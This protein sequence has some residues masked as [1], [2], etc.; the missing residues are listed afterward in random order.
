[1]NGCAFKVSRCAVRALGAGLLL[2][3]SACTVSPN[4]RVAVDAISAQSIPE[5][6]DWRY[7]LKPV[8][9][10]VERTDLHFLE[11]AEHI[12]AALQAQGLRPAKS[13]EFANV[14]IEVDY[15]VSRQQQLVSVPRL[16][17]SRATL[18]ERFCARRD[19]RGR[20]R[21]WRDRPVHDRL[22]LFD[23]ETR[24]DVR[25]T[26]YYRVFVALE[27]IDQRESSQR[28]PLWVTRA[29][30]E[31]SRSDLRTALP[32]LIAAARDYIGTDTGREVI[33]TQRTDL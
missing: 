26:S 5:A 6:D 3:I 2:L 16:Q 9:K 24:A 25:V 21:Q 1:M 32:V 8:V 17:N 13:A 28:S 12:H 22:G 31:S 20:C 29:R 10:G 11:Y 4:I 15:G 23:R 14:E 27:A 33:V 30:I 18:S 19:D 7:V